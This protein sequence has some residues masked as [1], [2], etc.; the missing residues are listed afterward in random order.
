MNKLLTTA[1]LLLMT[2][3]TSAA[4]YDP[5][6]EA[7]NQIREIAEARDAGVMMSKFLI[8][9]TGKFSDDQEQESYF[10]VAATVFLNPTATAEKLEAAAIDGCSQEF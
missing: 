5:C 2:A 7:G 9:R 1:L 3:H 4:T 8:E 6:I 10:R